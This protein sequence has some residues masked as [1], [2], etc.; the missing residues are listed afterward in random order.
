[1][2]FTSMP[3]CQCFGTKSGSENSSWHPPTPQTHVC[4]FIQ[5]SHFHL[6]V[7]GIS[8]SPHSYWENNLTKHENQIRVMSTITTYSKSSEYCSF[9]AIKRCN[10]TSTDHKVD[11][12]G[13]KCYRYKK[14]KTKIAYKLWLSSV[15][16]RS[17]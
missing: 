11:L 1:M 14:I 17:T 13:A 5:Y 3:V 6:K 10:S 12:S 9:S 7:N 16:T 8:V 4:P 2:V 15:L